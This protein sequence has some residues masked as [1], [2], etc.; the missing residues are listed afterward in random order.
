MIGTSLGELVGIRISIIPFRYM[1]FLYVVFLLYNVLVRGESPWDGLA[2]F[3]VTA[4]LVAECLFFLLIYTPHK[5]R[6]RYAANHP[7]PMLQSD[8]RH[9]FNK[10]MTNTPHLAEY[11]RWWFLGSDLRDIHRDNLREFLLWAFFDTELEQNNP[12]IVNQDVWDEINEYVVWIEE[13]LGHPLPE[14]RGPAKSLRLTFDQI[15]TTYRCLLWY[16]VV[17]LVDQVTH[18]VLVWHGFR[19]Y[20]R[21]S[22]VAWRTFPPR[23]QEL[24]AQYRSPAPDLSYWFRPHTS[25]RKRPVL[26]WHGIGIGLWTYVSFIL[27][28]ASDESGIIVPEVLPISFR[29]TDALP[30]K[31]ELLNSIMIILDH[32]LG[33]ERFKLVSHS[34]GSVPTTHMLASPLLRNRIESL[35]LI[36]PVT[37]LLH[38]PDVA[39]NFTR[40]RPKRANEWQLWYFACTDLGVAHCLGRHFFWRENILWK[41]D[42]LLG[43]REQVRQGMGQDTWTVAVCLSGRDLIVDTASVTQYLTTRPEIMGN[44]QAT[45]HMERGEGGNSDTIEV[46]VFPHLDHAQVFDRKKERDRVIE[47]VQRGE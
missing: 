32:H 43:S 44:T 33:W 24:F 38:L 29:L 20:A 19:Y 1:P 11:L 12:E 30:P 41:E 8:R 34:Y 21:P 17:F 27:Q 25:E 9:L 13:R 16:M 23:P 10:C 6:L 42:L 47:L 28:I 46:V 4:L 18:Y 45:D 22:H 5:R 37:I 2:T 14:G 39:Y 26:F 31:D 15:S 36:D 40:R 7:A 35:V 3:I